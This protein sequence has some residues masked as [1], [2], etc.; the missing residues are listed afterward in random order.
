MIILSVIFIVFILFLTNYYKKNTSLYFPYSIPLP[1]S[2]IVAAKNEEENIRG[3]I[4]SIRQLNYSKKIL[5]SSLSMIIPQMKH[6]L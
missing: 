3:L 2:I 1:I 6:I 5:N 4:D